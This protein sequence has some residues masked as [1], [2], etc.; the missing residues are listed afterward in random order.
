MVRKSGRLAWVAA[1]AV[2]AGA[3]FAMWHH[4][5]P[6]RQADPSTVALVVD[7]EQLRRAQQ[8]EALMS[9]KAPIG[10]GFALVDY[11]G[12]RRTVS[13]FQGKVVVLY[14]GYTSC[15]DV[16]PADL[17]QISEL[18]RALGASGEQVQPV[19]ITMDPERD[20]PERLRTYLSH[21]HPRF[22][23][24]TGSIDEIR[25]VADMYKGYFAKVPLQN[26]SNYMMDHS[27]NI[28]LID[29]EGRFVGA[30]PPATKASR[31]VEV[32]RQQ[33]S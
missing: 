3:A 9:A 18:V 31:L 15:P 32:V 20:T 2:L 8:M 4:D 14:F 23:G 16:C 30:F 28:Y 10:G 1:L 13:D 22:L 33:L 26:S 17:F 24:L 6:K 29:R 21:F 19:F 11:A 27:A 7:A 12:V 25:G 5:G